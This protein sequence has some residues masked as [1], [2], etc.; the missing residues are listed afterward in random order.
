MYSPWVR[1]D[2]GG[3]EEAVQGRIRRFGDDDLL[4]RIWARDHTV[5]RDDPAEVSDR[6][7]WLDAPER[8]DAAG[9]FAEEVV[10]DGFTHAVLLGMGG[11]SLA[12][13]VF[14][15]VFGVP[16]GHLDLG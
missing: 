1:T 2:L 9:T 11:S 8:A 6:L 16:P 7:G 15:R 13:E 12:P 10:A 3:L 4:A 14:R 5:W